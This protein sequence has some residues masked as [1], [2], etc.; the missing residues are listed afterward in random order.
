MVHG[1]GIYDLDGNTKDN[2]FYDIWKG[3]LRRCYSEEYLNK[4]PTYKGTIVCEEWKIFSNFEKWAILNYKDGYHL[5]KDIIAGDVKI[6]SPDT[7]AFVPSKIN[8]A[9]REKPSNVCLGVAF[10][11]RNKP[12]VVMITKLNSTKKKKYYLSIGE[13]HK[14]WQENKIEF[15]TGLITEYENIVDSRIIEG[16]N[17]RI[18][19]LKYDVE[20]NIITETINKI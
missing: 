20:H 12:Y 13:A 4:F 16:L 10:E 1:H 14:A 11:D 2:P 19:M 18:N 3:M 6:Y 7:C 8:L 15:L 9:I 17:R 5:D